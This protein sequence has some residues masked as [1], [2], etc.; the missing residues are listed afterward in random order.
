MGE[1][2]HCLQTLPLPPRISPARRDWKEQSASMASALAE[3]AEKAFASDA[4]RRQRY[5]MSRIEQAVEQTLQTKPLTIVSACRSF[6][7][8]NYGMC[9]RGLG[10]FPFGALH[11]PD[12]SSSPPLSLAQRMLALPRT[13]TSWAVIRPR[14]THRPRRSSRR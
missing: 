9:E 8:I 6:A 12:D 2:H 5:T 3:A 10:G 14:P 13:L 7:N 4:S 1:P 11:A